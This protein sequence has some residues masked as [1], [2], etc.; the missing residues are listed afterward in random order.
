MRKISNT[1]EQDNA[2][3]IKG[4]L[5][6]N[7]QVIYECYEQVYPMILKFVV[8]NSGDE[9]DAR[10]LTQE[11][12]GAFYECCLKP[13]FELTCKFSSFIYS[14]CR[15]LWLKK[16]NKQK[17][18]NTKYVVLED[19]AGADEMEGSGGGSSL[20][21]EDYESTLYLNDLKRLI[22]DFAEQVSPRCAKMTRLKFID[23]KSHQEIAEILGISVAASRKRLFDCN[24]KLAQKIATSRYYLELKEVYPLFGKFVAKY[25]RT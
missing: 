1:L 13:N 24:E 18:F 6:N 8:R 11:S 2:R 16:L 14:I 10:I 12:M 9:Q 25:L 15:N 7:D 20:P 4:F 23:D 5:N 17:K 19:T 21:S 22:M 3:I